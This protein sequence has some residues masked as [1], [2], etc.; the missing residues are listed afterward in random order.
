MALFTK[1]EATKQPPSLEGVEAGVFVELW[2]ANGVGLWPEFGVHHVFDCALRRTL[3]GSGF[4]LRR[5]RVYLGEGNNS[6]MFFY[7]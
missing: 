7:K 3:S 1:T 5:H 2:V 6:K 4:C